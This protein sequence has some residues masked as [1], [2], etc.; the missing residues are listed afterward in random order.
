MRPV[1][2]QVGLGHTTHSGRSGGRVVLSIHPR[3]HHCARHVNPRSTLFCGAT[4]SFAL[5]E[6]FATFKLRPVETVHVVFHTGAKVRP[7]S[8]GIAI[9][10]P[11]GLLRW[12]APDRCMATF[13][14]MQDIVA[15]ATA[16]GSIV[17]H[18]IEQV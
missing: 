18:W 11:A 14:D 16:L 5:T 9:D 7:D 8:T 3:Y 13:S 10:D 17:N 2:P 12:A 6:H 1:A 4:P 15:K